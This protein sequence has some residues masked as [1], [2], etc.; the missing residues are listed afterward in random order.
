MHV[1]IGY[2]TKTQGGL[3]FTVTAVGHSQRTCWVI[4]LV[5]YGYC[6]I[7]ANENKVVYPFRSLHLAQVSFLICDLSCFRVLGLLSKSVRWCSS[8]GVGSQE[9]CSFN[10][11]HVPSL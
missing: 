1:Y 5:E 2:L 3:V 4:S 9:S 8:D 6:T 10:C 7:G 11:S